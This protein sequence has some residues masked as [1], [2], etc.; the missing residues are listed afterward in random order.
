LESFENEKDALKYLMNPA[1]DNTYTSF[2]TPTGNQPN[3]G[4]T[5]VSPAVG[6]EREFS[7]ISP[8]E[9]IKEITPRL[10]VPEEV[11][12]AG[13]TKI[14]ETIELPPD[15]KK[16]GVTHAGAQTPVV[17]TALPPVTLPISDQQ[18]ATGLHA[19]VASALLWLA[20]WCIK[21]LKKAHLTLKVIHGKIVRVKT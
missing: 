21:K 1:K 10:E 14:G 20:V 13:V 7:S 19:Q 4:A 9:Q 11:E 8:S 16:L 18:V 17:T 12:K 3:A 5:A 15:V 2:Q 6:Q